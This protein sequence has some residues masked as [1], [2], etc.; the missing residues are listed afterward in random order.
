MAATDQ[1]STGPGEQVLQC[2]H[3]CGQQMS[4]AIGHNAGVH[5]DTVAELAVGFGNKL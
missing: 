3:G 4:L 5:N 2:P 1:H